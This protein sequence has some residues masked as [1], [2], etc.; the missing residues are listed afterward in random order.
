VI[1]V[2]LQYHSLNILK[3]IIESFVFRIENS[4]CLNSKDMYGVQE[5]FYKNNLVVSLNTT[6]RIAAKNCV[7]N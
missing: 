2:T 5:I 3:P 7:L 6:A 4:A 1:L